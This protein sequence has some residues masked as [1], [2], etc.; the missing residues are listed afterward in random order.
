MSAPRPEHPVEL[1]AQ[2]TY[3]TALMAGCLWI[4]WEIADYGRHTGW[5]GLLTL[6]LALGAM[7]SLQ[8]VVLGMGAFIFY[9]GHWMAAA[10]MDGREGTE[11]VA[12]EREELP[13][14]GKRNGKGRGK[15][16]GKEKGKGASDPP[17][18]LGRLIRETLARPVLATAT[19]GGPGEVAELDGICT[20]LFFRSFRF[21]H[22][23]FMGLLAFLCLRLAIEGELTILGPM[24][25]ILFVY[26][27]SGVCLRLLARILFFFPVIG[28]ASRNWDALRE[29][30][31]RNLGLWRV[32]GGAEGLPSNRRLTLLVWLLFAG[33]MVV[34]LNWMADCELKPERWAYERGR[35]ERV[36]LEF[37][38]G[39]VRNDRYVDTCFE[40]VVNGRRRD[41]K[42]RWYPSG[43]NTYA[44]SL[45]LDELRNGACHARLRFKGFTVKGAGMQG[46][47][48]VE[49]ETRF[50]VLE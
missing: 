36:L 21:L 47:T 28:R 20:N 13:P 40:L 22:R 5:D 46:A 9:R 15:D 49:A 19:T 26:L 25:A 43:T 45:P 27:V 16:K 4:A 14:K 44:C 3:A 33:L 48:S 38:L 10:M 37:R 23:S 1:E 7:T 24:A 18:S 35:D 11:P 34:N 50:F 31:H 6:F 8:I 39:G 41:T 32:G 12:P 29:R 17:R 2:L 30:L 42:G